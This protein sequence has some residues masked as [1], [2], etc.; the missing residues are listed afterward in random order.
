MVECQILAMDL[1]GHG[2]TTT[3][4]DEDL[5]EV[6]LAKYTYFRYDS[7]YIFSKQ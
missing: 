3:T 5:S 2:D 6:T 1:R 4:N 7:P